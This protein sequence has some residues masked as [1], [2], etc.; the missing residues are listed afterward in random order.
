MSLAEHVDSVLEYLNSEDYVRFY[1]PGK[2]PPL[3]TMPYGVLYWSRRNDLLALRR[4]TAD[5]DTKAF[6]LVTQVA[7]DTG[8][9]A[10]WLDN[11][12][13]ELL[14]G[15]RL[16]LEPGLETSPLRYESSSGVVQDRDFD[17]LFVGSTVW[18]YVTTTIPVTV[19]G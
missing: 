3:A 7:G 12:V 14:E 5:Y 1:E 15:R 8:W 6:R 10:R 11:M 19:G 9:E 2:V 16:T 4:I 17:N 18:T 13:A